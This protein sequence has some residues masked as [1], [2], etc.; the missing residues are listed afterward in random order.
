MSASYSL[1]RDLRELALM[2]AALGDYLPAPELYRRIGAGNLPQLTLGAFLLRA[3]RL[4]HFRDAMDSGQQAALSKAL[5]Q[6]N[7]GRREWTLHYQDKLKRE[8]DSRLRAMR[9]F[10]GECAESM[11]DCAA[12]WPAEAARR[13]LIQEIL[14]AM[15]D[16]DDKDARLRDVRRCDAALRRLLMR[17]DFVWSPGL[18][19]VYPRDVFWWLYARPE[20]TA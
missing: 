9:A 7:A 6:H 18:A 11:R 17:C 2:G 14:M 20:A 8:A 19:P 12:A 16:G 5:A 1:E 4:R 3:R 13:T 15:D 10:F